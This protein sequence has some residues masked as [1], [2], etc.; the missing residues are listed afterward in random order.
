VRLAELIAAFMLLTRLPV[1]GLARFGSPPDLARSVWAFPVVGLVVGGIG[2]VVYWMTHGL[3]MPP[4][5]AGA[6][7][8]GAMLLTTG[9]LHEDGLADTA[10]GLGGGSTAARKL[11]IM[12]DSRIGSYGALALG[13]SLIL[14]IGAIA[15]LGR[16]ALVAPALIVAAMLGR[17]GIIVILVALGPVRR[18]GMGAAVGIP[19]ADGIAL[20]FAFAAAAAMLL[21]PF[22]PAAACVALVLSVSLAAA[23]LARSQIGGY[24]GDILGAVEVAV[25][26]VVLCAISCF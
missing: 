18:D 2:A 20:G 10:D 21:L 9:A 25:E 14:R 17:A 12:R 19:S 26:C 16:T 7:T 22:L 13:L 24:T 8:V 5:L 15:A 6:W 3:G 1:A 23:R 4:L 11:E